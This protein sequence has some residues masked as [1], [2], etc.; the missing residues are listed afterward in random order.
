MKKT[1]FS[2]DL[3]DDLDDDW[4]LIGVGDDDEDFDPYW[5]IYEDLEGLDETDLF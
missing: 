4:G 3:Y 1:L 5:D 2:Y